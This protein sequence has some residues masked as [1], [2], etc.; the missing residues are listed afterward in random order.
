MKS[1]V[2]F[3]ED[4]LKQ[5]YTQLEHSK[6]EDQQLHNWISKAINALAN[7]AFSGTQIPKGL[8]PKV[9]LKK[10]RIDNL[11]KYDLP[12]GWRLVYSVA[13]KEV[14]VITIILEWFSHKEYEKRFKY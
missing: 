4:K 9:Y 12:K 2:Y 8:I 13:K 1:N 10:Y 3:A 14:C 7:N 6:T 5:A 11:W